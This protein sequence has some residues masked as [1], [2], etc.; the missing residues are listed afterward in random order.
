LLLVVTARPTSSSMA[1]RSRCHK[2]FLILFFKYDFSSK[3]DDSR[4]EIRR[5]KF[6]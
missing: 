2:H 1:K 6:E 4:P 5:G 3:E